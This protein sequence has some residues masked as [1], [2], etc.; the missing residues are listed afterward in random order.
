MY[1]HHLLLTQLGGDTAQRYSAS[2]RLVIRM[3]QV[4]SQVGAV[5]KISSSPEL[6]VLSLIH[7]S[8]PTRR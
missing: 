7:I 1:V 8:E 2:V 4:Q 5:G 3:S 6:A